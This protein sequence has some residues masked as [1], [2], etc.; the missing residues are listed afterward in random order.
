MFRELPER[1]LVALPSPPIIAPSGRDFYVVTCEHGGNRIPVAYADL[2]CGWQDRLSTHRGFDPGALR[3]ARDLAVALQAPLVA[4]TVSRLL[5]DLNRSL[6]N[7][8]VWSQATRSLSPSHKQA[9]VA[10]HYAPYRRRLTRIVAAAAGAGQRVVHLSSHSFT[11]I[12]DGQVRHA[13]VGLLYD[14][15]RSGEVA[16][17]ASWK[18]A[19]AE[20]APALR[21]RRNYPYQGRNDGL[22]ST[23]RRCFPPDQYVGIELELNQA[24]VLSRLRSWRQLRRNVVMA[25][26]SALC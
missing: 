22:M 10:R 17:A 2:F 16:A 1:V 24:F 25:L 4:S 6:S 23:L 21:V 5:V 15:S 19:L 9:I 18:A 12:L 3:M 20:S 26:Q 7:P 8:R 13:D 14:P 11:P